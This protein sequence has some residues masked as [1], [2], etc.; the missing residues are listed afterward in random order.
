MAEQLNNTSIPN[1]PIGQDPVPKPKPKFQQAIAT[2]KGHWYDFLKSSWNSAVE[3]FQRTMGGMAE[4]AAH[5][6]ASAG[7][8]APGTGQGMNFKQPDLT[9]VQRDIVAQEIKADLEKNVF[10]KVKFN[11]PKASTD[12]MKFDLSNGFGLDDLKGISVA[13]AGFVPDVIQSV[14]TFGGTFYLQ[15]VSD[16]ASEYDAAAKAAG[17]APNPNARM[18]YSQTTGIING[19]LQKFSVDRIFKGAPKMLQSVKS[20]VVSNVLLQAEKRGANLTAQ[21]LEDLAVMETKIAIKSF[22]N[23]TKRYGTPVVTG[24]TV[25]VAM[26]AEKDAAKLYVNKI[27]GAQV[28][29]EKEL[30]EGFAK[31]LYNS[32]A[33]GGILGGGMGLVSNHFQNTENEIL[34]NL[35]K[36][37]TPEK[38]DAITTDLNLAMTKSNFSQSERDLVAK[39]LFNY[40]QIKRTIPNDVSPENQVKVIPLIKDRTELDEE[41]KIQ[42]D[43][44]EGTDEA[45]KG[46]VND[47]IALLKGKRSGINKQ[48]GDIINNN[49]TKIDEDA[50]IMT[51]SPSVQVAGESASTTEKFNEL[52][53]KQY[54]RKETITEDVINLK[55]DDNGKEVGGI[56]LGKYKNYLTLDHIY[57][58]P[59]YR[60]TGK[61]K[62]AYKDALEMA[63]KQGYEGLMVGGQLTTEFKTKETYKNFNTKELDVKNEKGDPYIL[64]T[65]W[66]GKEKVKPTETTEINTS[67]A[68]IAG[69]KKQAKVGDQVQWTSQ[70]TEQLVEPKKVT[71]VSED[72]KYAF[73]EGSKTGIPIEQLSTIEP[74]K[75]EPI[76]GQPESKGNPLKTEAGKNVMSRID[77]IY[78]KYK[79]NLKN[80]VK[81][82]LSYLQKTKIFEDANDVDR[83]QMM[84]DVNKQFGINLKSAPAVE[85]ML[86]NTSTNITVDEMGALK[87]QLKLESKAATDAVSFV[88]N[89]R[90]AISN[91]LNQLTKK[92]V[93]KS[94]QVLTILKKYDALNILNNKSIDDFVNYTTKIIKDANYADKLN[95]ANSLRSLVSKNANVKGRQ[96]NLANSAKDFA[97]INPAHVENID[98]YLATARKVLD[99]IKGSRA[100]GLEA[101]MPTIFSTREINEFTFKQKEAIKNSNK[102]SMLADYNDLV[103]QG[104]INKE[105]PFEE[106][107]TIVDAIEQ[108]T[109]GN[110][111]GIVDKSR[112]VMAYA[113]KRFNTI[114]TIAKS[115]IETGQDPFSGK[116]DYFVKDATKNRVLKA[117]DNGLDN[118]S[119]QDA[120]RVVQALD[121]F[122]TNGTTSGL[123]GIIARSEGV[124][125]SKNIANS[126][127][128]AVPLKAIFDVDGEIGRF[129][130]TEVTSTPILFK[131]L[132]GSD[133][134]IKVKSMM[135]LTDIEHGANQALSDKNNLITEYTS[136]FKKRKANELAFNDE[137]NIYERGMLSFLKRHQ[138]GADEQIQMEFNRRKGLIEETIQSLL[139][140]GNTDA[141]LG[142]KYQKVYEK[143]LENSSNFNDVMSKSDQVNLDAVDWVT[144]K[145][146]DLYPKLQDVAEN[147]YNKPL[148]FEQNYIPDIY[149][150][151]ENPTALGVDPLKTSSF[152]NSVEYIPRKESGTLMETTS[153]TKLPSKN[154]NPTKYVDLNFD[155]NNF[156][157]MENAMVDV[158]TATHIAKLDAFLNS[159][160]FDNIFKYE[161]GR[162]VR[163]SSARYVQTIKNIN[164]VDPIEFKKFQ[165]VFQFGSRA[166]VSA[167]LGTIQQPFK[168]AIPLMTTFANTRGMLNIHEAFNDSYNSWLSKTGYSLVNVGMES[169]TNLM[170]TRN[171]LLA[172][173]QGIGGK[174]VDALT[175]LMNLKLKLTVAQMDVFSRKASFLSYYQYNLK[176]RNL[177]YKNLDWETHQLDKEAGDYA[178]D[179]VNMYMNTSDPRLQ[180]KFMGNR[181]AYTSALRNMTGAFSSYIMNQKAR[182]FAD[183][184]NLTSGEMISSQDKVNS[185]FSLAGTISE[186]AVFSSLVYGFGKLQ[187][188][189]ADNIYNRITGKTVSEEEKR[190]RE[191]QGINGFLTNSTLDIVSPHPVFNNGLGYLSNVALDK[192]YYKDGEV[193]ED[194]K[195]RFFDGSNSNYLSNYGF[196]G[197]AAKKASEIND[198]RQ[199]GWNGEIKGEV[200]GQEYVRKVSEKDK[201][202]A[203]LL[204]YT[205]ALANIG[206]L[207]SD[208]S[209]VSNKIMKSIKSGALTDADF[210]MKDAIG[211]VKP[212]GIKNI[213]N[214]QD[215]SKATSTALEIKDPE[216]RAKYIVE[217]EN[218]YGTSDWAKEMELISSDSKTKILDKGTQANI[219]AIQTGDELDKRMA[220]V[221]S[222]K[223][224]EDKIFV[225]NNMRKELG[226]EKFFNKFKN[227]LAFDILDD[228][229]LIKFAD[230]LDQ[231]DLEKLAKIYE[232]VKGAGVP[233]EQE[234]N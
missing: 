107:S 168:Q 81:S 159:K 16:G 85:R 94:S 129:L 146:N 25:G 207:P 103:E 120:F 18:F 225:L 149:K 216:A 56:T 228:K 160:D 9:P 181:D 141:K 169:S 209:N 116:Y 79:G 100:K 136:T 128:K 106:M 200:F 202:I 42:N 215:I 230:K 108:G 2:D 110:Q 232:E 57:L 234:D 139:S 187:Y 19:V 29:N 45:F 7:V 8:G 174:T 125:A 93:V 12:H 1:P 15:G 113:K 72:G 90:Q 109:E 127:I 23:L 231:K 203:R 36:A 74:I 220:R 66:V 84:R 70:G 48:I 82:A 172:A 10:G 37:N 152:F 102:E 140:K 88:K 157:T 99:G 114:S 132:F 89:T 51:P 198:M 166:V 32:A 191:L 178:N 27:Q 118:L 77:G 17:I 98:A 161:D 165:K 24:A 28:F 175:N 86:G 137:L 184:R 233:Q 60:E 153:P 105:M 111:K 208:V 145:W 142:Q 61:S 171:T 83:E 69:E 156:K 95:N 148:S 122:V 47:H 63:K 131:K 59:E 158:N 91:G 67:D 78:E 214:K 217:L 49:E 186:T 80:G 151:F 210:E 38:I 97:T 130:A 218:Q 134:G 123:D 219:I 43:I 185:M 40:I 20:K 50:T 138:G 155:F 30:K 13:V 6:P 194:Y 201:E 150:N 183:I 189:L 199:A 46:E 180:G 227:I 3:S 104:V 163:E 35:A 193:P 167:T 144:S 73:I 212:D 117:I 226:S 229:G 188:S 133:R 62:Y 39:S 26:A 52:D 64:L 124:Q 5:M 21:E 221:F 147:Y 170:N 173:E 164:T 176:G 195:I 14:G 121:N 92:G 4:L 179:M 55:Y 53:F 22:G 76:Q 192:L 75:A 182:T 68:I 31:N 196:V 112:Y 119:T 71:S 126:G 213:V 33:M 204:T 34:T 190:K 58:S 162:V 223:S 11:V 197:I 41:I 101:T 87:S 224:V 206:F 143:V 65:D 177:E 222:Q 54:N 44:L 154:D 115:I 96:L 211:E 205:T 135:G